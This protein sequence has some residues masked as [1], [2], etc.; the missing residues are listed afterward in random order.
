MTTKHINDVIYRK[1]EKETVKVVGLLSKPVKDTKV[2][3]WLIRKGLETIT[4][5]DYYAYAREKNKKTQ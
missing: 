2:L 4:E 3:E 5:D 1:V